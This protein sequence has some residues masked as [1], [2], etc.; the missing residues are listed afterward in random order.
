MIRV[1]WLPIDLYRFVFEL[2]SL[3]LVS[4]LA[5]QISKIA[6]ILHRVVG[7]ELNYHLIDALSR[8]K[9]FLHQLF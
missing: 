5:V 7:E 8:L 1:G 6:I 3:E 4:Q 2:L 9:V